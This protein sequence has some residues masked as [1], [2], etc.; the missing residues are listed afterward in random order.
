MRSISRRLLGED[1]LRE[2]KK[3]EFAAP[4]PPFRFWRCAL[5]DKPG[6]KKRLSSRCCYLLSVFSLYY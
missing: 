5:G 2:K 6:E 4:V 3:Q 1:I